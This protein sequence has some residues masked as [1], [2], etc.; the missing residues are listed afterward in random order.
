M[1]ARRFMEP[2]PSVR[3]LRDSVPDLVDQV[4]GKALARDAADRFQNAS[5]L[6]AALRTDGA[7]PALKQAADGAS[8]RAR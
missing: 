6:T 8:K 1:I 3:R 5:Q 2:A 7:T 4:I